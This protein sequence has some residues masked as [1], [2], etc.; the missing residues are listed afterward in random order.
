MSRSPPP[1]DVADHEVLYSADAIA[2]RVSE[3][4]A[5][6]ASDYAEKSPAF[7]IT[8]TGAFVF[9]SDLLRAMHPNTPRG[10]TIDAIKAKSYVGT[11]SSE[12]VTLSDGAA[13]VVDVRGRHVVV[14]EDIVDT[15]VTLREL[16]AAMDARGAASVTCV[17]LLNKRARRREEL[18]SDGPEY[19]GFECED[20]FVVGY[21]LDLDGRCR[22]WPYVGVLNGH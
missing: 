22:E 5:S 9:A 7:L 18:A 16:R 17:A 12:R 14:I 4:A 1:I 21:G 13:S 2:R 10:A 6:I 15:G 20:R 19:V 3:L 11:T 8:M